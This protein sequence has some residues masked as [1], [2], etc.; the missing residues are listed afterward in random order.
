MQETQVQ[1]LGPE[2]PLEK[3]MA[4][5]CSILAWR[6][7]WT[8]E[9][10]GLPSMGSHRVEHNIETKQKA[11][12]GVESCPKATEWSPE[13]RSPPKLIEPLCPLPKAPD[14]H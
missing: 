10:G 7:A 3:G 5:H 13:P 12:S 8:E 6:I 4:T 14:H 11:E 2:D 9:S 1:S